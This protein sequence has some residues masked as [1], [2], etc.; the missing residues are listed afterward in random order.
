MKALE[1]IPVRY[2][3]A[4]GHSLW[5]ILLF[6]GLGIGLFKVVS[7]NLSETTDLALK[8]QATMIRDAKFGKGNLSYLFHKFFSDPVDIDEMFGKRYIRTYARMVNALG[9]VSHSSKNYRVNL[10]VT[11]AAIKR[12]EKGMTTFETF[13]FEGAIATRVL[14]MPVMSSGK[15]TGDLIQVGTSLESTHQALKGV[16]MVLWISLPIGLCF[17]VLFGYFFTKRALNPVRMMTNTAKDL[18]I[19]D[20][21]IRIPLPPAK[22]ELRELAETFNSMMDRLE[23]S[24]RRLRRFTGDV[25]HELRTPLAVL[26]AEAEFALRRDRP[27]EQYKEAI[28]RISKESLHMSSII[29]D[30]LLLA[31]A[32][33]KSVAMNWE[34]L[35]VEAFTNK[36]VHDTSSEF[37]SR[38]VELKVE[39]EP[40]IEIIEASDNFL[41]LALRNIVANAAKHSTYGDHVRF[42]VL[43]AHSPAGTPGVMF[44]IID[45][46]EGIPES[47]I[48]NI[49]DPF[50]RADTARNRGTGGAGIGLSLASALVKLHGGCVKVNSREGYGSTFK[51][52]V[53]QMDICEI[54]TK[55]E[56]DQVHNTCEALAP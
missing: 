27:A 32:E 23:D 17:A 52:F 50:Y 6:I 3:L 25:S 42:R 48:S 20:L 39:I 43:S 18:S 56:E 19:Q 22:D 31:R 8:S 12:A 21:A 11:P 7:S 35:S 34:K 45:R 51:V 55:D 30:L 54:S 41:G 40:G 15:F 13:R 36:I 49:F 44:E 38:S 5:L 14:T 46:G 24:V 53:P 16:A 37:L 47:D 9:N 29:E 28:E 1:T 4:I 2:R 26:R 10:P 33:S